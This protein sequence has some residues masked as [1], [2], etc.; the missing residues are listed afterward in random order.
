MKGLAHTKRKACVCAD[1]HFVKMISE[2]M[3]LQKNTFLGILIEKWLIIP[4]C[5][6]IILR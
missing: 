6:N 5:I 1:F 4:I 2:N 3:F